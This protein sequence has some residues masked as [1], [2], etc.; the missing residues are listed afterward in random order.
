MRTIAP[1]SCTSK[2]RISYTRDEASLTVANASGIRLSGFSPLLKRS[3]NSL[4]F[5]C[6]SVSDNCAYS[7]ANL[8]TDVTIFLFFL[9]NRSLRLPTTN[10][11]SLPS[12]LF[13][14]SVYS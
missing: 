7:S 8:L 5:A 2:C 9:I 4:V 3:L 1:T 12:I 10:L 6:S 14:P 11:T 13:Y